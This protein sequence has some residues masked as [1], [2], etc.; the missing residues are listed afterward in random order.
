MTDNPDYWQDFAAASGDLVFVKPQDSGGGVVFLSRQDAPDIDNDR[1]RALLR[2]Y[3]N[4]ALERLDR[5]Q[6]SL[7]R[8]ESRPADG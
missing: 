4:L 1:D 5:E 6:Y 7:L 2:A 8:L 3:L